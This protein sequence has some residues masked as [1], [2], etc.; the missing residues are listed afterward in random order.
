MKKLLIIDDEEDL[1]FM[2][3]ELF[4]SS[5]FETVIA[6]D[7]EQA[8][9]LLNSDKKIDMVLTDLFMPIRNGIDVIKEVNQNHSHIPVFVITAV[10]PI[11]ADVEK[12]VEDFDVVKEI[13]LKPVSIKK[14][15]DIVKSFFGN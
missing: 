1:T 11:K 9:L 10:S 13:F 6:H 3:N 4:S 2:L 7:G 14:L 8:I 15:L 5:G 12:M